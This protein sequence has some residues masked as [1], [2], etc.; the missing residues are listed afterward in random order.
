MQIVLVLLCVLYKTS[1]YKNVTETVEKSCD[2]GSTVTILTVAVAIVAAG[3]LAALIAILVLYCQ[4][5]KLKNE[6]KNTAVQS[7]NSANE[8]QTMFNKNDKKTH[9]SVSK[10]PS[11]R[12][13]TGIRLG[14]QSTA[15]AQDSNTSSARSSVDKK[16]D[17]VVNVDDGSDVS[18]QDDC[19]DN[20]S[21]KE[22]RRTADRRP[23]KFVSNASINEDDAADDEDE[24]EDFPKEFRKTA[25][26]RPTKFVFGNPLESGLYDEEATS[27]SSKRESSDSHHKIAKESRKSV[28]F[29]DH[30]KKI[31]RTESEDSSEGRTDDLEITIVE[32]G[33][34]KSLPSEIF[35]EIF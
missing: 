33:D 1:A 25:E 17:F 6:H 24:D 23:T 19:L 27:N 34:E 16:V 8:K 7:K 4:I 26:R 30:I 9:A 2:C 22:F 18:E 11:L 5:S 13:P 35:K 3:L 28:T 29:D 21:P 14:I 31:P 32:V 12:R 20:G 10:T 15:E